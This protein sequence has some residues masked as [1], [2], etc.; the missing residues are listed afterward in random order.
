MKV[1]PDWYRYLIAIADSGSF[2]KGAENLGITQSA[3]SQGIRNLEGSLGTSLLRRS[4]KGAEVS[5]EGNVLLPYVREA[6]RLLALGEQELKE[7]KVL[8]KGHL[9]LGSG[10]TVCKYYLLPPIEAFHRRFPGIRISIINRTSGELQKLLEAR[11]LDIA[12]VTTVNGEDPKVPASIECKRLFDIYDGFAWSPRIAA[13]QKRRSI[14]EIFKENVLLLPSKRTATRRN[15]ENYLLEH[16]MA[17]P[18]IID[19]ESVDLQLEFAMMGMGIAYAPAE[20]MK[21]HI[22]AGNLA[23]VPGTPRIPPRSTWGLYFS[24]PAPRI[25]A[26]LEGL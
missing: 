17:L 26:F 12:V 9:I 14:E 23:P 22:E 24:N 15:L 6:V 13:M 19:F 16:K 25:N 20:S 2:S 5:E 4:V 1:N 18:E 7:L 10:D 8:E 3:L 11:A 21:P